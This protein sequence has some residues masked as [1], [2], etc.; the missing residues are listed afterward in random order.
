MISVENSEGKVR[1]RR[2][3][4]GMARGSNGLESWKDSGGERLF[5]LFVSDSRDSQIM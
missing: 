3:E 5:V 1:D 4:K 2:G